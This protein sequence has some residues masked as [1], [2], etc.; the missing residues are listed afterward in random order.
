MPTI[1]PY[2]ISF[3]LSACFCQSEKNY[4]DGLAQYYISN[5]VTSVLYQIIHMLHV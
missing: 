3:I 5:D 1:I 2:A 4:I